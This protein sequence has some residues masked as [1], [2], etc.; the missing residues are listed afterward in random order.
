LSRHRKRCSSP[1]SWRGTRTPRC[2]GGTSARIP[3]P[4]GRGSAALRSIYWTATYDIVPRRKRARHLGPPSGYIRRRAA[5]D[6]PVRPHPAVRL[7]WRSPR[8]CM[9]LPCACCW[10]GLSPS[11]RPCLRWNK[12][13]TLRSNHR[14]RWRSNCPNRLR[15]KRRTNRV[16]RRP[17][18]PCCL[19]S[20]R[21]YP[22]NHRPNQQQCRRHRSSRR[23]CRSHR[24][25][26]RPRPHRC[27]RRQRNRPSRRHLHP[28][29]GR[30]Q[31]CGPW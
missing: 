24:P 13:L 3:F 7:H 20:L 17:S 30:G 23:N 9:S 11:C 25:P 8:S 12:P 28:V 16:N 21:S 22:R 1:L 5:Q 31:W 18:R 2:G 14:R 6:S 15:R 4:K 27:Q 26:I 29:P 10:F 19:K